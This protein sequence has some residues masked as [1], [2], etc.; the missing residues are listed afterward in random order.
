MGQPNCTDCGVYVLEFAMQLL[1]DKRMLLR[2]GSEIVVFSVSDEL[3]DKWRKIGRDMELYYGRKNNEVIKLPSG[4][5]ACVQVE[6]LC[7]PKHADAGNKE[8]H[9]M[10]FRWT[11]TLRAGENAEEVLSVP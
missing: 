6:R 10:D 8:A 9:A 4:E 1:E 2:L 7:P 3:R 5:T 11:A